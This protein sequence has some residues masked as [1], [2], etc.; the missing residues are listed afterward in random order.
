[1]Y[2]TGAGFTGQ[3]THKVVIRYPAVKITTGMQVLYMDR[4]F[5]VQTVTDPNENRVELDL[6][7]LE[8]SR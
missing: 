3:L 1:M 5:L 2:A 4:T 6:M 8:L 7:C